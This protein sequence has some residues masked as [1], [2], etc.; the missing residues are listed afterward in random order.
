MAAEN[1]IIF[2]KKTMRRILQFIL[3]SISVQLHAQL[4]PVAQALYTQMYNKDTFR[5]QYSVTNGAQAHATAD[6]K[7]FYLKWF[8]ASATPSTTAL[9]VTLHG[10]NG[11]AFNEFFVWH[12]RAAAKGVGIIALQ[13]YKGSSSVMPYDYFPDDSIYGY[14]D[15][16]LRRLNYPSNKA[17]LHG[18]S[19]GSARSYAITFMDVQPSGKNYF[20]TVFS[21]AG[22]P[23]SLYPLYTQINSGTYGHTFLSGKRWGMFCGGMDSMPAQSGCPAMNSAKNWVQ[24]NGGTVGLFI[25]DPG[26]GHGGFTQTAAYMDS[27]L[28][29]YLPCFNFTGI[30][31]TKAQ[32]KINF[33]PNP[34][35]G[36][37]NLM[38]DKNDSYKIEL[39]NNLGMIVQEIES[40]N[41]ETISIE[42]ISI[43]ENVLFVRVTNTKG[44][45]FTNKCL[46]LEHQ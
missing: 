22:K 13:W 42:T 34:S 28:S 26:L 37:I 12:Q 15:T 29:Y 38:L 18:F 27:A 5:G 7:S 41:E 35:N 45:V 11:N 19:R 31:E 2:N 17:L 9:L 40:K 25:S 6:G 4:P 10:S 30:K 43:K 8:P 14:I 46:L 20:C 1:H 39:I 33:F 3:A 23:D 36:K 24:A 21:N 44:E 16:A 32:K